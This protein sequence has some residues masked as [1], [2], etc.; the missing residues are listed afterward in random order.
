MKGRK[1]TILK[2]GI[3]FTG[4]TITLLKRIKQNHILIPINNQMLTELIVFKSN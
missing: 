4:I 3:K 2:K 1:D